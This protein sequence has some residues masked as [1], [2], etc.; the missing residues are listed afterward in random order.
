MKLFRLDGKVQHYAWGGYEYIPALLGIA[1][2]DKPS[3]EYWMGAHVSAPSTITTDNGPVALNTLIQENPVAT[4]GQQIQDQFGQLP[5]LFKILDVKD[6]LSIQVHPTKEEAEKGFARENAAGLPANAPDRNYKDANHK[7]EIMVALSEFWLLHGFLPEAQLKKVLLD[8]P[9]FTSLV[10]IY[11]A[12]GYFGLYKTVME[13]P[14]AM[15]NILLRPL[16][17]RAIPLYKNN[18][19]QKSDPAFWAARAVLN[20]PA[21]AE[22]LDRGIFS[23]YFFN[24]VH[25]HPGQAVFQDAGIP[26]AYLEGQNVELMANSDNVLRGGLTPKHIDVPELL[27]HTRFEAVHPHIIGGDKTTD[28]LETIYPTPAPD[29]VVSDINIQ[30]G[31]TYNHA[32]NAPEIMIVM[33]G[34]ATISD[35]ETTITLQKGQCVF[36]AIGANYNITTNDNA[37]IYKATV[38]VK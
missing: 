14:Q 5:Y 12:E 21:S 31:Q 22:K 32:A 19:L 35:A 18:Q 20:D 33:S 29:F 15:V 6:M 38:P 10:S 24:I 2:T 16:T 36:V 37:A 26:H 30:A 11:D 25:C 27:K 7:P 34:N 28:G 4:I 1:A 13:M 8:T 9:E 23:I 17:E 3:A